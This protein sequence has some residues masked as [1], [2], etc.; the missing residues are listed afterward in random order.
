MR[1]PRSVREI[2]L[3]SAPIA[4]AV[5]V[6]AVSFGVLA[7]TARIPG[8]AAVLMSALVFA[9]SAQFAALGVLTAGGGIVTAMLTGGLLNLRYIATGIAVARSLPGG[10]LRRALLGQLVVDESYA[11]AAGAGEPGRPDHRTLLVTGASLYAVWVLGTLVGTLL[12]PV[13]GDP[14]RLGLDA[15][16]PALFTALLWPM[17]SARHAV[18]CA[19]GG[20]LVALVLAPFTPP[21]VPL[22]GAAVVGLWLAR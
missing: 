2:L 21:G 14:R 3:T 17:L 1:A 18:R 11:M 9:G 13:L 12:G 6:F 20:A 8:W 19:I 22:A 10:P 15:A 16:F 4:L 5:F 7:I